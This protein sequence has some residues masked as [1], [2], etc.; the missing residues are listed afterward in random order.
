MGCCQSNN[1]NTIV[2]NEHGMIVMRSFDNKHDSNGPR[3]KN[4]ST[5]TEDA[6]SANLDVTRFTIFLIA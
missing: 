3:L 5:S 4:H 2:K 1:D 6:V